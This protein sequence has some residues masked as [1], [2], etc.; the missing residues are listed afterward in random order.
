MID[1]FIELRE[2]LLRVIERAES[3]FISDID[4]IKASISSSG[5]EEEAYEEFKWS[6][7]RKNGSMVY[8]QRGHHTV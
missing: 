8:K 6:C 3:E 2:K 5:E 1:T 7:R 4:R